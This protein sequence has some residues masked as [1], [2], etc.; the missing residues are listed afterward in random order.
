MCHVPAILIVLLI[1]VVPA[2]AAP[3]QLTE[4]SSLE[5]VQKWMYGYR[6]KPEPGRLPEA[7]RA[8]NQLGALKDPETARI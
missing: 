8:L 3:P 7:I 2:R 1:L 4:L 5:S 6:A